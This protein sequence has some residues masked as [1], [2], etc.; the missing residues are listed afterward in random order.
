MEK[1]KSI[2]IING[3]ASHPSSNYRI[4]EFIARQAKDVFNTRIYNNLKSLP[5]F[6]PSLSTDEPP[7]SILEV[8]EA[9]LQ[10]DGVIICSPEYIFSIP[11]G[12]KNLFEWC[13]ATTVFNEKPVGIIT[14]AAMGIKGHEELQLILTTLMAQ[15][16]D[17]CSLIIQ[18]IKGKINSDGDFLDSQTEQEC[19]QFV[20]SYKRWVL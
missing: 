12:L 6:D 14:A 7:A 8:R 1:K 19:L 5:H 17:S 9:I 13:V 11:S 4:I 16:Q 18:G 20:E 2:L 3:S 10:A 15:L